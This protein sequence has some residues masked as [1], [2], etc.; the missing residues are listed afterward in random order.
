MWFH[1]RIYH[2]WTDIKQTRPHSPPVDNETVT[3]RVRER[4]DSTTN[5]TNTERGRRGR[6]ECW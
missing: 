3:L 6:R 2:S 5:E 4:R 1:K